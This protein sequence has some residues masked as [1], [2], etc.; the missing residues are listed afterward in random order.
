[1]EIE[2]QKRWERRGQKRGSRVVVE[3][4]FVSPLT[5]CKSL[6][7]RRG[8]QKWGEIADRAHF[9]TAPRHRG[10]R[11]HKEHKYP[12]FGGLGP[13]LTLCPSPLWL[14]LLKCTVAGFVERGQGYCWT[15]AGI[16]G[17]SLVY[18]PSG[19]LQSCKSSV[20]SRVQTS[21]DR[22]CSSVNLRS[23]LLMFCRI[24]PESS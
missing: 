10:L 18:L 12:A 2:R 17:I 1:M 14:S 5:L 15:T 7:V 16:H 23:R 9:L 4:G 19:A 21:S 6:W 3:S 24:F 11:Q 13:F 8:I 22:P 20:A